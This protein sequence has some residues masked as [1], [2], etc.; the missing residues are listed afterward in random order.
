MRKLITLSILLLTLSSCGE[1]IDSGHRGVKK[2]FGKVKQ[3]SLSEGFYF[4]FPFSTSIDEIDARI[5]KINLATSVYTRDV[6]QA[7]IQYVVNIGLDGS[8]VHTLYTNYG[9]RSDGAE[10]EDLQQKVIIPAVTASIKAVFG[11]WNATDVISNRQKVTE[12]ISNLVQ[13]KLESKY[14]IFS[15]FEITN[16]DYADNFEKAVED[17][18]VAIQRAEEAKNTT[19][20]IREEAQQKL[21]SAKAEAESMKIRARALSSNKNLVEY[22]A[23]QKWDGKLPTYTGGGA[24]PFI[25]VGK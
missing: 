6:Q 7:K 18:V 9:I 20:R 14:I 21:I 5:K 16:I 22:E 19:V 25:K 1:I 10:S 24:M 8:K 15:N 11:K 17:K 13:K 3:E 2:S 12:S 4:Y 23:V